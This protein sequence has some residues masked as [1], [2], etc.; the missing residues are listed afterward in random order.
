MFSS[1]LSTWGW[2]K[3]LIF[4]SLVLLLILACGGTTPSE[5]PP[6]VGQTTLPETPPPVEQT[7]TLEPGDSTRTLSYG[8]R[9]RSYVLHIPV[10]YDPTQPTAVVLAFHG[11][12]LD[13]EEMIRISGY[14]EQADASGFIVVYPNGTGDKMQSWNGGHCCG[15]AAKNNVDDVGFVRAL[16][17]DLAT[18]INVDPDRVYATGFSNGAIMVYRLA[19]EL[20]DQIAAIGPVSATQILNDEQACHPGRGVPVIHFH[21]T[22]DRLNP[23]EGGTTSAGFEIVSVEHAIQFWAGNNDCPE[24]GQLTESG[25]II[26]EV[27]APCSQNSTVELYKIMDGEHA[28]PGGEAVSPQIGEPTMEISATALMWEFFTAHPMP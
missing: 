8:G 1:I 9:E 17:E 3:R 24:Q 19:C 21:G 10:S 15:E 7:E 13:A 16:I 4:I 5:T 27:H 14:S 23:Y 28:W 22:A 11:I 20:S 2:Q 25:T 26:H 12:G 6:P 18:V